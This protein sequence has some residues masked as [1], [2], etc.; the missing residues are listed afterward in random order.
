MKNVLYIGPYRQNDEWGFTSRAFASL[1]SKQEDINLFIKPIWFNQDH[2][3]VDIGN[4]TEYENKKM[5]PEEKEIL[6]QHGI[7]TYLNYHGDF[8]Q[9]IIVLSIDCNIENTNWSDHI[10]LFDKILVFSDYE[11]KLLE[12]SKIDIPIVNFNHPPIFENFNVTD[13]NFNF[14]GLKFYAKVSL[15]KKSAIEEIVSAYLSAFQIPDNTLLTLCVPPNENAKIAELVEKIKKELGINHNLDYYNHIAIA[16]IDAIES[17]NFVHDKSDYF[18]DC[19]YNCRISQDILKA[20]IFKSTPIILDTCSSLAGKDYEFLV[21]SN[22]QLVRYENRPIKDL[23]SGE[24]SWK[25]PSTSSLRKILR[26]TY[27][28]HEKERNQI[29]IDKDLKQDMK[30]FLCI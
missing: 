6:I 18:I 17:M 27:E 11:K 5:L 25:V 24:N 9:N 16:S 19:S 13:I 7:P 10:G 30:E 20:I 22:D 21:K 15:D 12:Q 29:P 14:E 2:T 8:E 23:Y 28:T 4:L 26:Y 3:F 1:L